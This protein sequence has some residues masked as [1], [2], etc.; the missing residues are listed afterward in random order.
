MGRESRREIPVSEFRTEDSVVFVVLGRL[1]LPYSFLGMYIIYETGAEF[2]ITKIAI[3]AGCIILSIYFVVFRDKVIEFRKN[4]PHLMKERELLYSDL[5]GHLHSHSYAEWADSIEKG[6]YRVGA[7]GFEFWLGFEKLTF[8]Y[9][10]GLSTSRKLSEDRY[11]IFC[12]YIIAKN[13][14]LKEVLPE[15]NKDNIDLLDK[16]CY[17]HRNRSKQF[18]IMLIN[19][20]VFLMLGCIGGSDGAVFTA[21]VCGTIEAIV[22]YNLLKGAFFHYK[23]EIELEKVLPDRTG[24]VRDQGI[25]ILRP[26]WGYI[27]LIALFGIN[28]IIQYI[29]IWW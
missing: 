17:Y 26:Y 19:F 9:N 29:F 10:V 3:I 23:N 21:M 25:G 12:Q 14:L 24:L 1:L 7:R 18:I 16:R 27:F 20:L 15:F 13:P 8:Y 5:L 11:T 4:H 22:F 6:H 2:T 28:Y